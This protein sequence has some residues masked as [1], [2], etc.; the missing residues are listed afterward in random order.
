MV[1]RRSLFGGGLLAGLTATVLPIGRDD[2]PLEGQGP[3]DEA[4]AKAVEDVRDELRARLRGCGP[5]TCGAMEQIRA[6]QK[7][8]L[9]T[10]AKFPDF[11][12]VGADV[13]A[14]AWDW[15]IKN[16]QQLTVGRQDNGRY[17]M[18]F[19]L[20]TLVLRPDMS[21]SYIGLGYEAK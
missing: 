18:S 19:M 15:H 3:R 9:K 20:S 11:I 8:F 5:Y 1:T 21:D 2:A 4:L 17:T 10:S 13:W 6:N 14:A 12:D 16:Q 7:A